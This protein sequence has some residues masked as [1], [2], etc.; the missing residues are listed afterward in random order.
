MNFGNFLNSEWGNVNFVQTAAVL[1]PQNVPA[2]TPGGTTK[3][4]FWLNTFNNKPI[5]S[6][7]GTSQSF[8]STYYM[9]FGFR[10]NFQ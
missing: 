1:V 3:P 10:Y 8:A 4:T 5:N 6:T 2:L 7:F 9:Q